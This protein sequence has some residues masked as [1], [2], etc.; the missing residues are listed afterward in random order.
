[1][2]TTTQTQ[3]TQASWEQVLAQVEEDV[4]RT[5]AM[6]TG[7]AMATTAAAGALDG[8]HLAPAEMMLPAAGPE[9]PPL[10]SMPP[11]PVEM[12]DRIVALR[13]RI[14]ALREEIESELS[15]WRQGRQGR[16]SS[17]AVAH[18]RA[19]TTAAVAPPRFVD[20]QL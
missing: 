16:Q 18:L 17:D 9:L 5:E 14:N 19:A 3:T 4:R 2:T 10:V 1:M 12:L 20:R 7:A 11:I 13:T 15:Q 6:L 8:Q